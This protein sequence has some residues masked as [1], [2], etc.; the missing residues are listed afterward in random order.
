VADRFI[1]VA[2]SDVVTIGPEASL[3]DAMHRMA[4]EGVTHLPVLK[5]GLLVGMCTRADIVR[6]RSGDLTAARERLERQLGLIEELGVHATGEIGG[7]DPLTAAP[8]WPAGSTFPRW[9]S[10]T[11]KSTPRRSGDR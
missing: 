5:N 11:T 7:A 3:L 9:S 2:S 4:E 8:A 6:S 1:T 10:T